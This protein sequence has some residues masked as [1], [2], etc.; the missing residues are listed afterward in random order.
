[1]NIFELVRREQA[2]VRGWLRADVSVR[3]LVGSLSVLVLGATVLGRSRWIA[4]PRLVPFVVWIA[5]AA[6]V[7]FVLR[8]GKRRVDATSSPHAIADAV[9]TEQRLRR[10]AVRGLVELAEDGSVF[11]R[12][13]AERMGAQLASA[14]AT[15][16]PALEGRARRGTL[17]GMLAL[18]P[19]GALAYLGADRNG[20]G[21][22]ALAH[23]VA[24]WN[25]TLLAPLGLGDVPR[26]AMRGT[27][28]PLT[29]RAV[30][31]DQVILRR[32]STGSAWVETTLDVKDGV[33]TTSLGPLDADVTLVVSDGRAV[34]DSVVV[35]VVDRP[36][37]GDVAVRAIYPSYLRRAAETLPGD[38]PLHVPRGTE[39]VLEG[40]ASEPLAAV[41][42]A[43]GTDSVRLTPADRRF[44][45]RFMPTVSGAYTWGARGLSTAIADVPSPLS[46]DV[47]PDSM[48]VAE[49]LAPASDSLVQATDKVELQLLATDDHG[50]ASV[51][52][53]VWKVSKDGRATA[54]SGQRVA[55]GGT[56]EWANALVLDLGAFAL[57]AGDAVH[58]QLA[59]RDESP[60]GQTGVS[61]EVTLR[62]PATD[63]QRSA[64]RAAADSA[65]ARAVAAAKAQA[66]LNQRTNEAANQR[67]SKPLQPGQ[68]A[69]DQMQYDK[70]QQT[71]QLASDQRAMAERVQ[72]LQQASKQLEDRLKAAN[73]LDTALAAQLREA[74]KMLK[75][76]LTPE[77]LD[78]LKKLEN[79]SQQLSAEQSKQSL[80]Q[81]QEQ[82]KK[83]KE[84][85]EKSAEILKRAALEGAMQTLKDEAKELAKQQRALADSGKGGAE[86]AAQ[87]KQLAERTQQLTK[88]IEAL[89]DRL[90]K[91]G[92]DPAAQKADE[93]LKD[94]MKG[95][96]AMDQ[97]SGEKKDQ[98]GQPGQQQQGQQG[99]QGQQQQG[100]QQ[101]GQQGQKQAQTG[102]QQ[103]PGQPGQQGQQGQQGQDKQGQ[104]GQKPGDKEQ[105]GQKGEGQQGKPGEG[106][107]GGKPG[108]QSQKG[109]QGAQSAK[110]QAGQQQ[111]AQ[112]AAD[113][114]E[115]A[116][117]ALSE[118]RKQQVD[119][120]KQEL[121]GE[122]DQ[123][124]Q[125]MIQLARQQDQ[126]AQKAK[127][128]PGDPSLRS[129]QSA[130]Q[131]GVQKAAQRLADQGKRS[132]LVSPKSQ[133]AVNAA[134]QKVSQ[135]AKDAADARTN[136]QAAGAMQDAADAL[137]QAAA[138]LARDRERAGNA[139][140]STGLPE[141]LA[142]L[143]ALAQQQGSLNGQMQNFLQQ[144]GQKS[145]QQQQADAAAQARGLARAQREV[146]K[147]LDD[148]GD[149]DA[150]GKSQELA[151]E[152]RQLAQQLEQGAVDPTVYERQQR[153][154]KRMLDAG[155]AL[156]NDQ[157]DESGK[158]E[159][160]P[161][162]Q[163]NPF[164][165]PSANTAGKSAL[166][167]RVPEWNELRGLSPAERRL[168]IE[169]FRRL[170]GDK[171]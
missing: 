119:Q 67:S 20:D 100:Q 68:K 10:G 65:A 62:V 106:G 48:P 60:W 109:G 59:V 111:G 162:D 97:A 127:Q 29:V 43:S 57:E 125:E 98:P 132:A 32:R 63:E 35:R 51:V 135:A 128:S 46:I 49:I 147:Q 75:E 103:Q 44:T 123:S 23:P 136:Q 138:S 25:G 129:E 86:Q 107:E 73:A 78:A 55:G 92:A 17:E 42:L 71:K 151:R 58:V 155:R 145:P 22:R 113:A 114:L 11:V 130:L 72:Q 153:L 158:R 139:Q 13:A 120:W 88:D 45:G 171:P 77:M 102:Q 141:L 117:D 110:G 82:Q 87:Q 53:N 137:R 50:L 69:A 165:P 38:A 61:R 122:L 70:A 31:R 95:K 143:Q 40:H 144:Q 105:Q 6:V 169:Y 7:W 27:T 76:A 124:V 93:A 140:S 52:L 104:P 8:R 18:V 112:Q 66:Q 41:T 167:Y 108:Q 4:L 79:S 152:A 101:Q 96:Q 116:A 159:S 160:K 99:Q 157:K 24:A 30:G 36:F 121:T 156:E 19:L 54:P 148:V 118:G 12:R 91:E 83:M 164:V 131:Q 37:L 149:A 166:K 33:A 146:A 3:A 26:R 170:N 39:L 56:P 16:A 90:K 47:V 168:V 64:A 133:Q 89:K 81:L 1:V 150:T 21:W 34:S 5:A 161:G 134:E 15:L 94:A 28:V 115:K 80:Q 85:L 2:R 142:Q 84:A 74:Q 154:F 9:E 14:G 163:S 126:L